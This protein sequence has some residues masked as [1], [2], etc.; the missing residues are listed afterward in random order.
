M[1]DLEASEIIQIWERGQFHHPID[2][3]RLLLA[4]A[5][6]ALLP[7]ELDHLTIGRRNAAL[8]ALRQSM[9]GKTAD[10]FV[11]CPHCAAP[12]EFTLDLSALAQPGSGLTK[13]Q[14]TIHDLKL[15]FRLP[16]SLDLAAVAE[17]QDFDTGRRL[18]VERCVTRA[19]RSGQLLD[20][21]D[22]TDAELQALADAMLECEP[23]LDMEFELNCADC[24]NTW[25]ALFDIVTFFWTELSAQ[26][27][28]LLQQ[29]HTLA[30]AYGWH[31]ADILALTP[32]RR[33]FY[34]SMIL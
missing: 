13:G 19:E 18:L 2:R 4:F 24:G 12:L 9:L 10:C 33:Q 6:P 22:L 8:M 17:T 30:R 31:E 23:Q 11:K 27:K 34:L 29:V 1:R 14:V 16:D 3:G 21:L 15:D 5:D 20:P 25:N 32:A 28:R 7:V 26:A